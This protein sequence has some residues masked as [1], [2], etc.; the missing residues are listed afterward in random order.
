MRGLAVI[1]LLPF[2]AACADDSTSGHE[3]RLLRAARQGDL[4]TVASMLDRGTDIEAANPGNGWTPLFWAAVKGNA[5]VI[6][7]L[8]ARGARIE[9]RDTRGLTPLMAAARWGRIDGVAALLDGGARIGAVDQNGW[10]ALMW[11]SFKGQTDMAAFLLERGAPSGARDGDGNTAL[12]LAT[13]KRHAGT[14]EVLRA[15]SGR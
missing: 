8:L 11:A 4:K 9:A 6:R 14:I 2:A 7:L 1:L 13:M 15:S 3:E 5:P 12:S 10:N